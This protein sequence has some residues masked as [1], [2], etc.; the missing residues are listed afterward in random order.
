VRIVAVAAFHQPFVHTMMERPVKLLLGFQVAA[1]AQ[2]GLLLLH[3]KLALFCVVR[4]VTTRAANIVLQVGGAS[5]IAVLLTILVAHQASRADVF[6]RSIFERED[7]A[8]VPA[9]IHV[10]L[11]W[12]V[13]SFATVPLWALASIEGGGK[14]RR[15]LIVLKEILRRHVF[16]ARFAGFRTHVECGIGGLGVGF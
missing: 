14:V 5:K 3:Q 16:V 15:I 11:A 10:G 4:V 2:L 6:R 12:T 7:L 13:A 1:V 9:A 8:F